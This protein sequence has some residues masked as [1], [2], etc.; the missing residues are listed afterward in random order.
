[1][2]KQQDS[3]ISADIYFNIYDGCN[4]G[5]DFCKFNSNISL[6]IL[7]KFDPENFKNKVVLVS[8]STEPLPFDDNTNT[9]FCID[10]LHKN[11]ATILFLSRRPKKVMEILSHFNEN[12]LIGISI[13]ESKNIKFN[14]LVAIQNLANQCRENNLKMWI[15][16]EP[17]LSKEF[18]NSII[19]TFK[20]EVDYIRVGKLD[21]PQV[22][23]QKEWGEIKEYISAR[24]NQES[25]ILKK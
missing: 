18:T 3:P 15:S 14:D 2:F 5:C 24:H 12:D 13:S 17:V 21:T 10:E 4:Q 16:L 11:N 1:M 25:V 9:A 6:P 7:N 23:N 20:N 19:S 8:Y 22:D